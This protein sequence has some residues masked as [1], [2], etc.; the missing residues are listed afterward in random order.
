MPMYQIMPIILAALLVA[1]IVAKRVASLRVDLASLN[2]WGRV[3]A[4]A[5]L[6]SFISLI[7][8]KTTH[9]GTGL[10]TRYGWPKPFYFINY[11]EFGAPFG[12][13]G[14]IYFVGNSAFYGAVLLLLWTAWRSMRR[15]T[16]VN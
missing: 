9:A 14:F 11:P 2:F 1:L 7:Y 5:S 6:F 10:I 3:G 8:G 16:G 15:Q 12:G 13:W 4:S